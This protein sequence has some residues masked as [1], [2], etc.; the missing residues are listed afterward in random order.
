MSRIRGKDTG[1][2]L[3]VRRYL[4]G[5]R[6]RYRLNSKLPGKPDLVFGGRTR[7]AVFCHGCWFHRHGCANTVMPKTNTDFW[8]RKFDRTIERDREVEVLLISQ[9]WLVVVIWECDI[10]RDVA[11]ATM[12]LRRELDRSLGRDSR[13][14]TTE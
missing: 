13:E 5:Q 3:A 6:Y 7:I 14:S 9:G 12:D 4:H 2:E 11:G 8:R 10:K 1:P